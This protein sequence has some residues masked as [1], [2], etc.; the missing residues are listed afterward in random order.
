MVDITADYFDEDYY[1]KGTKSNYKNY[2]DFPFFKDFAYFVWRRFLPREVLEVGCAK[3]FIIKWMSR[4]C[5]NAVGI[6]ISKYAIDNVPEEISHLFHCIDFSEKDL[7][8]VEN[9]SF[10]LVICLET[11]EHVPED[12]M[13]QFI[14]NLYDCT[15]EWCI[16]ST[17]IVPKDHA[18]NDDG[19]DRSHVSLHDVDYWCNA[20]KKAG[21]EFLGCENWNIPKVEN[22]NV[23]G[24]EDDFWLIKNVMVM[25]KK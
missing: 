9:N 22:F 16:V 20:F 19:L 24:K 5:D 23:E 21:F 15:D 1:E 13:E 7:M 8:F 12:K 10:D 4:L 6:D 3:G 11:I 25:R 14:T 18:P 2:G 17:P